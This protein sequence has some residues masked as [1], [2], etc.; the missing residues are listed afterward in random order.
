MFQ[1]I[2]EVVLTIILPW[3]LILEK[4][5]QRNGATV[6]DRELIGYQLAPHL[7]VF[8]SQIAL[9]SIIEVMVPEREQPRF[10]F[11]YT[12]IFNAYRLFAID[13]WIT[14]LRDEQPM[15]LTILPVLTA[16]LWITS[17][18]FIEFVWYP[19]LK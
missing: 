15:I 3:I 7:F 19:C 10:I 6:N 8:Q 16:F 4:E 5:M 9:E 12:C 2:L 13:A 1:M 11:W 17:N 18:F 14:R